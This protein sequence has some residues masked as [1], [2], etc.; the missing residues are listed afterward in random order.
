MKIT[1]FE[2]TPEEFKSVVNVLGNTTIS[3]LKEED[4]QIDIKKAYKAM[5][6]RA[7]IHEGQK[8]LYRILAKGEISKPELYG[9]M[10]RSDEQMRGVLGALGRRISGTPEIMEAGLPGDINAIMV[11]NK[12]SNNTISLKPEFLEVLIEEK[13][14]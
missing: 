1:I 2:G 10:D 4:A 5:L 3:S 7:Q 6:H 8:D 11:W 9:L 14:I 13:I 12:T